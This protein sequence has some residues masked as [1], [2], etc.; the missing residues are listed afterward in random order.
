M[1]KAFT[2]AEVIVAVFLLATVLGLVI[3]LLF[4]SMFMFRAEAARGDAQQAAMVLTTK[5]QRALLN[6]S[7]QR[8]WQK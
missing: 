5:L 1:R 2:L 3:G 4:P 8:I 6:T 7:Q